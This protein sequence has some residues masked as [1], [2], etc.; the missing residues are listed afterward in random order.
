M[1]LRLVKSRGRTYISLEDL[2]ED[3]YEKVMQ[4]RQDFQSRGMRLLQ[5]KTRDGVDR[6]RIHIHVEKFD[7]SRAL[8]YIKDVRDILKKAGVDLAPEDVDIEGLERED[9][10][11]MI[12]GEEG[13]DEEHNVQIV[14]SEGRRETPLAKTF[15]EVLK[16]RIGEI[17]SRLG[18]SLLEVVSSVD[19]CTLPSS[20][21]SVF[22]VASVGKTRMC[23][24]LAYEFNILGFKPIFIV[25]EPNW[26]FGEYPMIDL[27]RD[28]FGRDVEIVEAYT[29]R[30]LTTNVFARLSRR[31]ERCFVVYDSFGATAHSVGEQVLQREIERVIEAERMGEEYEV[32]LEPAQISARAIPLLNILTRF[33]STYASQTESIVICIAHESQTIMRK[34]HGLTVKPSFGE[35]SLHYMLAIYRL[36]ETA[37]GLRK[38]TCVVHRTRPD[39]EGRSTTLPREL[40]DLELLIR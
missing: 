7:M 38:L 17:K 27:V 4:L 21:Y 9:V 30:E 32:R 8:D 13:G 11:K 1:K 37:S 5:V 20:V 15:R 19:L 3:E 29:V 33:L 16:R 12:S 34:W 35:R 23:I 18:A 6:S 36:S 39:M 2:S 24:R 10:E 25:S 14:E 40:L 22:G 31:N 26:K 28:I